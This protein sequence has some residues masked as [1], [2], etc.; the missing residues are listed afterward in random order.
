MNRYFYIVF[1][2]LNML[3]FCFNTSKAQCNINTSCAANVTFSVDPPVFNASNSSLTFGNVTF[4]EINC[5]SGSFKAGIAIYIYQLMPDGSRTYQCTVEGPSPFNV[6]GNITADFGQSNFCGMNLNIGNIVANPSNGFE[7]CDGA[8]IESEAVL[9]VTQNVNFNSN[10]S[11]VYNQLQASEYVTINLGII[12]ININN[13]FPGNGQ[14]LTTA[15]VNDFSTG[16]NGPITLACGEDIEL[17]LEGLSRLANCVPYSDISAGIPSELEN[18]FYYSINGG[19]PVIIRDSS[20]GA[21]GGQITGPDTNL[22]GLCYAGILNDDSPYVLPYADIEDVV[23]DGDEIVFTIVTTDLFTTIT[24]QD[25]ITII[26]SGGNCN[27]ANCCAPVD[28]NLNFDNLPGQTSWSILDD[29]N[30]TVASGNGYG[31]LGAYSNTT[32]NT[33]LV[34]GCYTLIINDSVGNGM[35]PFQSNAVGVSTFITPGTLITPGS[36]VGTFSLVAT[37]GLCGSYNLKDANGTVLANGGGAF[38]SSQSNSFCLNDGVAP[39][40]QISNSSYN[41]LNQFSIEVTPNPAT[42]FLQIQLSNNLL[43]QN[44]NVELAVLD[45]N[46]KLL[47]QQSDNVSLIDVSNLEAGYYL[48]KATTD[49]YTTTKKFLKN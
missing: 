16:G 35:C 17:Y 44:G 9:Y 4:G 19:A 42:N 26:Y 7:P 36:I 46:G 15:I 12:N 1:L 25:E 11:S 23:C 39:K 41:K 14:P 2:T 18:Q 43:Q 31:N 21:S 6:I 40:M 24:V 48:L 27:V 34:D 49:S 37:P 30:N 8:R 32:E 22:G 38:G 47:I 29:N 13:E 28:L 20:N 10:N 3:I 5:T 45:V 33:C